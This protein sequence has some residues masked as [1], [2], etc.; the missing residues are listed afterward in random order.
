MVD[1]DWNCRKVDD[2]SY[3]HPR[4]IKLV[5]FQTGRFRTNFLDPRN[6]LQMVR[7]DGWV[8][9]AKT[10]EQKIQLILDARPNASI[11]FVWMGSYSSDTFYLP[12]S[13]RGKALN[14]LGYKTDAE[15]LEDLNTKVAKLEKEYQV[16]YRYA[17]RA[18]KTMKDLEESLINAKTE[19]DMLNERI[20]PSHPDGERWNR[21]YEAKAGRYAEPVASDAFNFSN[22]D[23]W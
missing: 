14:L 6:P 11:H 19:R 9:Y 2:K 23:N 16:H 18:Q 13:L 7:A 22:E 17:Q 4:V 3:Y 5:D 12:N 1:Y 21:E 15:K 20:N 8:Y 10:V